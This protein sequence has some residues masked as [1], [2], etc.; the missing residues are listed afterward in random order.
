MS[1]SS[2]MTATTNGNNLARQ[3]AYRKSIMALSQARNSLF[4]LGPHAVSPGNDRTTLSLADSLCL[5]TSDVAKQSLLAADSYTYKD[6]EDY[7]SRRSS[8]LRD[9]WSNNGSSDHHEDTDVLLVPGGRS[10]R[11]L[12]QH[13]GQAM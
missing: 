9:G 10:D 8:F 4:A 6:N 1:S 7:T 11:H 5:Q 2:S 12:S 3:M 13:V